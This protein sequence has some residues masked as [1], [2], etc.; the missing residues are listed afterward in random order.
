VTHKDLFKRLWTA[1]FDDVSDLPP[2]VV[3]SKVPVK[4][5]SKVPAKDPYDDPSKGF[6][7]GFDDDFRLE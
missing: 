5:H 2:P 7:L 3:R 4:V 1:A 6:D